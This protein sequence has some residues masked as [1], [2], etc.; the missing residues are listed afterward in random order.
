MPSEAP[1]S[2]MSET[3]TILRY[4]NGVPCMAS[5]IKCGLKFF[6]LADK[7]LNDPVGAERF[8]R[9]KFAGHE[10]KIGTIERWRHFD[11]KQL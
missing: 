9:D 7:F 3:F 5:C 4:K 6:T 8:L 2:V 1:I 10:C 11:G